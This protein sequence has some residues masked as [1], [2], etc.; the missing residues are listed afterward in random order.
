MRVL[1]LGK[2]YPPQRGGMESSL[3]DLARGL[4]RRGH[5][6][7]VL[8]SSVDADHHVEDREGVRVER[9]PCFGSV[10]SL[11]LSPGLAGAIS[12][13]RR[14]LRPDVVHLHL[15]N[16]GA[17]VAWTLAG[18][19]EP[20]VVSY[21]SDIVRQRWL[22]G[23]WAPFRGRIL[24]RAGAIVTSTR[25]LAEASPGL[26]PW[27]GQVREI[28][29]SVDLEW[30]NDAPVRQR[31]AMA[32][33]WGERFLLFVGRHVYYKGLP[34]LLEALEDTDLRL[35]VAGDGPLRGR[36]E[37]DARRRGVADRVRF[38][39]PVDD[40]ALRALLHTCTA[41]VLPSTEASETFGVVQLEAMACRK[42]VVTTTASPGMASVQVDGETG[43]LVPPRDARALRAALVG[44]WDDPARAR[45]MG[46]AGRDRAEA[47]YSETAVMDR[48]EALLGE[49]VRAA[50]ATPRRRSP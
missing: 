48:W 22:G 1:E 20:L 17:A 4:V 35:V 10:R 42:P 41:L 23:V 18:G 7:E 50:D 2:F 37:A 9:L 38:C 34:V 44:L 16:P 3:R 29:F 36:W 30:W 43:L 47:F 21:H 49:V 12:R 25:A 28:P 27:R 11:P 39:G 40:E 45:Q 33:L 19:G 13:A 5:Q 46:R 8:V 14:R 26:R 15:P 32:Q 31:Q 24:D 6:V